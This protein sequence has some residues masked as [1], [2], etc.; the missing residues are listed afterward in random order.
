MSGQLRVVVEL[1]LNPNEQ[2]AANKLPGFVLNPSYPPESI[3]PDDGGYHDHGFRVHG[4]VLSEALDRLRHHA[5][6]LDVYLDTEVIEFPVSFDQMRNWQMS[7]VAGES[8][9]TLHHT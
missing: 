5:D 3:R 9:E 6:V 4:I 8:T 1:Q 7:A 2:Q